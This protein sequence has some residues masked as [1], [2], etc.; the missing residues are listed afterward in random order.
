MYLITCFLVLCFLA[1]TTPTPPVNSRAMRSNCMSWGHTDSSWLLSP[2]WSG[3]RR[4]PVPKARYSRRQCSCA[5]IHKLQP[6][7]FLCWYMYVCSHNANLWWDQVNPQCPVRT[8]E[9]L[10]YKTVTVSFSA[11]SDKAFK[12]LISDKSTMSYFATYVRTY[13]R[14]YVRMYTRVQNMHACM[15]LCMVWQAIGVLLGTEHT[16]QSVCCVMVVVLVG[17]PLWIPHLCM[18]S[19]TQ[20][21]CGFVY[22]WEAFANFTTESTV[23]WALPSHVDTAMCVQLMCTQREWDSIHLCITPT[24]QCLETRLP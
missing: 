13:L 3:C 16:L 20:V 4:G 19:H 14:T 8:A 17:L 2:L 11:P 12:V 9:S 22:E 18:Y 24:Y 5:S 6:F 7:L 10:C 23:L 1:P 21:L 15:R